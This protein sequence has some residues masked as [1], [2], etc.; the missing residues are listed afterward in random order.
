MFNND[1][2]EVNQIYMTGTSIE[3]DFV[4]LDFFDDRITIFQIE[5]FTKWHFSNNIRDIFY[6][7]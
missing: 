4:G 2:N 1:E 7:I 3:A 5:C 6:D